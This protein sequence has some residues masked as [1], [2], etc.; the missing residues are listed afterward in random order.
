MLDTN[1][2]TKPVCQLEIDN[3]YLK[4]QNEHLA[5]ELTFTRYTINALKNMTSQRDVALNETRQEL[6]RALQHIELLSYTIKQ[7]QRHSLSG[8]G[9]QLIH[10]ESS[11]E[12]SE[13][14]E[15]YEEQQQ[16]G[17]STM[18]I[19]SKLPL[20]QQPNQIY[21]HDLTDY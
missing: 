2:T 18:N 8:I 10:D 13:E 4:Q 1:T 16:R 19:M 14:D 17:R 7:Q 3:A 11:E 9:P 20:R 12:L 15:I 5:K 21:I 6:E